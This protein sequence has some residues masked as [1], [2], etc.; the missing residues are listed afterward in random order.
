MKFLVV[1]LSI[2]AVCFAGQ[3]TETS[4]IIVADTITEIKID[5]V[6]TVK[7]DTLVVTKVINDTSLI[8]KTDTVKVSAKVTKTKKK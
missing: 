6:K 3:R 7:Y 1:V 4:K 2:V 8:V 5:T